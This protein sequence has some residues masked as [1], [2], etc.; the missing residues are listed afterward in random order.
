MGFIE[1]IHK[2]NLCYFRWL[3]NHNYVYINRKSVSYKSKE[4]IM[5]KSD[6]KK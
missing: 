2:K 4:T 1:E 3:I 5:S 6:L